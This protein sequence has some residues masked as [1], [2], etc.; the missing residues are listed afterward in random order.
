MA[1]QY[2]RWLRSFNYWL[3]RYIP[4]DQI[5]FIPMVTWRHV[6]ECW[7]RQLTPQ[8]AAILVY[9]DYQIP[10]VGER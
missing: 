7:R 3:N 5:D 6:G 4:D 2:T 9:M 1:R 8:D 10:P